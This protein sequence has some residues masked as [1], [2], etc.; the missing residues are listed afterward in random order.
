MTPLFIA[1]NRPVL[2]ALVDPQGQ[3][4]FDLQVGRYE[5]TTGHTLTLPRLAV[6]QLNALEPRPGEEVQILKSWS[7][8]PGEHPEW[9]VSLSI[10]S[11]RARAGAGEGDTLTQQLEA[12]LST[13]PTQNAVV[14]PPTP[15]RKPAKREPA[16]VQPRLFDRG[17]GTHGPAIQPED[18]P[19]SIPLPAAAIGRQQRPGQIPAN[20]AVKE[21]L[22]FICSDPS[23]ANWS[24]QARQDM[25]STVYIAAVKA[26]HVGLWERKS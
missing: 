4:D 7:G 26:G 19:R 13:L 12:S 14:A 15:I 25:A 17:T 24:D 8:K 9:T 18:V 21:I 16:E 1:P 20:I 22:A 2:V 10:T 23:T 6:V 5:T 3:Y 11:E